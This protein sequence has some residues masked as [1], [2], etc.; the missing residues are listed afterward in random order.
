[1]SG[2]RAIGDDSFLFGEIINVDFL[3]GSEVINA[4]R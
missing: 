1:M 3:N 4:F 2:H